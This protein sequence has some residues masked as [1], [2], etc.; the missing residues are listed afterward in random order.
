MTL[1]PYMSVVQDLAKKELAYKRLEEIFE[2]QRNS[3]YEF[4][5][6]YR[7]TEKKQK[8]DWNWHIKLICDKLEDVFYGKC[9]RL[10][11]NVPPRSLK[12]EIV[13]RIFPARCLGKRHWIK[14]MWISYSSSLSQDNSGDCRAI[15]QSDTFRSIFPR[16][17]ALKEDQNTKQHR[18]NTEW[19]QYYASGSTG[20]IT[21]KW[22]DIMV[23]DDPLK[24]DDAMSDVVR[25]WVNNNFHNTLYSRLNDKV[26]WA[27]VIIMQRLHDDDL[28]WHL[29]AQEE[30]WDKREKIVIKAIAEEDDDYRSKGQSFFE[31]RFPVELLQMIK[32]KSQDTDWW[33]VFSSQY[34]QE[35]TNK[36]TQEFHEER[37]KYHW[38]DSI[39][40]PAWLRIFTAVD[41]A[42]KQGQEN[43][44]TSI[45]TWWFIENRLYILE[46]TAGRMTA[47]VM[48]DK[49]IYHIKKRSP[50]KV[51]IEAFQAQSMIVTFLKQELTKQRLYTTIEEITQSGDKLSKIRKLISL[52]RN[53]L[54]FHKYGMDELELELKRFPRWKHDDIIDS[55]QMLYNMYELQPNNWSKSLNI[56][57]RYD[58]YWIPYIT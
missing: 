18:E 13:S 24:P 38:T 19:W 49:I 34:Q 14:F 4:L 57:I 56:E 42:F 11:I 41:P 21:G 29:I 54:I 23:I 50:E 22:C 55:L 39:P 36:E 12:T 5:L 25:V 37:Y 40:T 53:W 20:T 45:I 58:E 51:W 15:Y 28:C 52:Y 26:E 47:D 32:R 10:M 44:Q 3:L 2:T 43:D 31:K 30:H 48:Q 1:F 46:I 8:L 6:Y 7:E 27:I 16:I 17:P 33:I 9:K 35:P